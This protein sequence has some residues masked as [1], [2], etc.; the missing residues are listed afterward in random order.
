[1][2]PGGFDQTQNLPRKKKVGSQP[3]C[4]ALVGV[5]SRLTWTN[6]RL[7]QPLCCNL[8]G[9][10][11][12]P[13]PRHHIEVAGQIRYPGHGEVV[14]GIAS[15]NNCH[16]VTDPH[17]KESRGFAFVTMDTNEGAERCIK[18][19]NRSV[20]EGRLI[21]V[22]KAKRSRGRTPTPGKYQGPT[23]RRG[24]DR[25][26][27]R[28]RSHSPRRRYDRKFDHRDGRRGRSPSPYG[29]RTDDH[30]SR[31]RHGDRS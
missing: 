18:Y 12:P 29:R 22:Q 26:M 7:I 20:L 30:S 1:M 23:D 24:N 19:L 31:R 8:Q 25:N 5:P 21:T 16:L 17:T 2:R 11:H 14:P 10:C 15:V 3:P 6:N 9:L 13:A 4:F 27:R 28:S